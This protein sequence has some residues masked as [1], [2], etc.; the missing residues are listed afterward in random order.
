MTLTDTYSDVHR[1]TAAL[2]CR[3]AGDACM[4]REALSYAD[5]L[6]AEGGSTEHAEITSSNDARYTETSALA[7]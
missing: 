7:N 2:E 3:L 4:A 5:R 6:V 1:P